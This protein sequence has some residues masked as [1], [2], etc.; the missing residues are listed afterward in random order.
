MAENLSQELR[1]FVTFALA[2]KPALTLHRKA[3]DRGPD[4]TLTI[5]SNEQQREAEI[6]SLEPLMAKYKPL[7]S[8]LDA[9]ANTDESV[10]TCQPTTNFE[11]NVHHRLVRIT[12]DQY[13]IAKEVA[14]SLNRI[15]VAQEAK[16][17]GTAKKEYDHFHEYLAKQRSALVGEFR[18]VQFTDA[19][20]SYG[21]GGMAR[22]RADD[23]CSGLVIFIIIE[24][25]IA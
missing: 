17:Y 21:A 2:M 14:S 10:A 7:K 13:R 25:F 9:I 24:I 20:A 22:R 4:L 1:S 19:V 8:F 15:Y 23:D 6:A 16:D 18:G 3:D 5:S 11:A 12:Q